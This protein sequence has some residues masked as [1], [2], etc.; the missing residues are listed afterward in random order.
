M[1]SKSISTKSIKVSDSLIKRMLLKALANLSR[2]QLSLI[3]ENNIQYHFKGS[4]DGHQASLT[5]SDPKFYSK[6]LIGGSIG[7]GESYIEGHWHTDNLTE[8]LSLFADNL[9][10]L[11]KLEARFGWLLIPFLKFSHWRNRNHEKQS[12]SNILA[13]Y[14]LGNHLY[15]QFLDDSM[16]YSSGIFD[17]PDCSLHQSQLNKMASILEP[18]DLTPQSHLIEIGTGW[19]G[20]A[21]YAAQTYGCKVTTTTISDAQHQFA[22]AKVKSL[23]LEDKITLLTKD[24]RKLEGQYDALVSV[25][26]IEAVGKQYMDTYLKKCQSLLKPGGKLSIQAITI[27][28]NRMRSYQNGVDFIQKYIFPGGF[29]PSVEMISQRLSKHT[30]LQLRGIKDFGLDYGITLAKWRHNFLANWQQISEHGFDM[31]FKRLWLFYLGYCEAGF[32]TKKISVIQFNAENL[33]KD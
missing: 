24:Y 8:L 13:H 3:D 18:L 31:P 23:G 4:H 17:G 7:L 32:N 6:A 20:L 30:D 27:N 19:G 2:G 22:M 25:E 26:M 21:I 10:W 16:C 29:L 11:D 15:T 12:K 5:I 33:A 1:S 28:C 14:D 9:E